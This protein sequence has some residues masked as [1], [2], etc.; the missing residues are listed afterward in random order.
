MAVGGIF[1]VLVNAFVIPFV[2]ILCGGAEGF[3]TTVIA[4]YRHSQN[5]VFNQSANAV[6][7]QRRYKSCKSA[8]RHVVLK[9]TF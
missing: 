3:D 8:K 4:Y 6:G 7:A 2:I 1:P 5:V 9:T